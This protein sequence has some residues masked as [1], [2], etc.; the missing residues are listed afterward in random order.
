[1]PECPRCQAP[2]PDPEARFCTNCGAP[3]PP[4]AAPE[5][6]PEPSPRVQPESEPLPVIALSPS[7]GY[8]EP[9]PPGPEPDHRRPTP[10]DRRGEIGLGA[11]LIE[12]TKQVITGPAAFFR[13][14]PVSG[15]LGGPLVYAVIVGYVGLL[16][17]ALYD[18]VFRTVMGSS[19]ERFGR[20][21]EMERL[22]PMMPGWLGLALQVVLG[23]A[24]VAIFLFIFAGIT[25]IVLT[26]L[27]G[28]N[29]DFEATFRVAAYARATHLL[30]IVLGIVPVCG[31]VLVLVVEIV[32][33]TIGLSEVHGVSRGKAAAAI[34]LPLL[35]FCC[36][37]GLLVG[38]VAFGAMRA[39]G[40][41]Q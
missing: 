14:M 40:G 33:T 9:P 1:M 17:A 34:L 29:R 5:P 4:P 12:T 23:P 28:A 22:L 27:G 24:L 11:A 3:L 31:A 25:H 2:L 16:A 26:L 8:G 38:V 7:A 41:M 10:W 13:T 20:N 36:C 32:V 21:A 6:P 37:V 30:Q 19:F 35:I 39:L 18:F 15:G